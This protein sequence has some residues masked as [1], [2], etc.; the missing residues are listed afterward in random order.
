[1]LERSILVAILVLGGEDYII[2]LATETRY[3]TEKKRERTLLRRNALEI[4]LYA[5][6]SLCDLTSP[7]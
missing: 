5:F 3:I 2:R 7:L 6:Q 1:M 4:E